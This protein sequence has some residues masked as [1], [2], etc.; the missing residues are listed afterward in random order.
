MQYGNFDLN[1][2]RTL[3]ALL[4]EK[5]VT[6]AAER[7][8]V[9]QP[10]VSGALYRLRE[11]FKDRLLLRMGRDMVLTPL[12]E[13]LVAPVRETLLQVQST[14]ATRPSFEPEVSR[15][16]FNLAMSDYGAAVMMPPLLRRLAVEAP[17]IAYSVEP[18]GG[19]TFNRM[20]TGDLDLLVTVETCE[21]AARLNA[22]RDM[23]MRRLQSDDFVC[24]IDEKHASVS[25]ALTL[26]D[27]KTLPHVVVRFTQDSTTLV[28]QAWE[29]E[30]LSLNIAAKASSFSSML[31]MVPGTQ[32]IATV[33]RRF[34]EVMAASLRL[35]MFECP[36]TIKPLHQILI[37]HP[38]HDVDPGH[39]YLR[40]MFVGAAK[41][42]V[43]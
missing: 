37:W 40:H 25:N 14:L 35:R 3:D 24:L 33:Q 29:L 31:F 19:E 43:Q 15:R 9:T 41:A 2:L 12:A 30:G 7:L 38:R 18:I 26:D 28:E 42:S 6:R 8:C 5:S 13:S 10:A 27:Y 32:M 1:L 36:L 34:A 11:Y 39:Q 23:K 4:V 17:F 22:V 21:I 16:S 20:E